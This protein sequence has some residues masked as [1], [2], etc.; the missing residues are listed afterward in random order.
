MLK[1][2][3]PARPFGRLFLAAAVAVGTTFLAQ[4]AS[5]AANASDNGS[6][7]AYSDGWTTGDNGGTGFGAW[8]LNTGGAGFAGSYVG[9]TGQGANSFGLYSGNDA[10]AFSNAL[11]PFT[12]ALNS[13]Q[14]FNVNLG[15]T[16]TING[17][18]GL[19]LRNSGTPVIV[20]KFVTGQ[21][22]W[23]LWDGGSDFSAGQAYIANS[24]LTFSFTYNGGSSYSYT[25]GTGS[26]NNYLATNTI[27]NINEVFFYD[28]NQ[29]PDQN[30]GFNNLSVVPEPS[31]YALLGLGTAFGLWQLRR[32]KKD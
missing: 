19:Q 16:A 2:L 18:L 23:Q 31:T 20:L 28:N 4:N 24:S 17:E 5:A 15:H 7:A 11:R 22:N 6:N 29:G 10:T 1:S 27:S 25:F 13:G 14:T 26:G 12:G 30:F 9:A 32:R 3:L 8:T 21:T